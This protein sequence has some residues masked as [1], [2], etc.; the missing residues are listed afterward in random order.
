MTLGLRGSNALLLNRVDKVVANSQAVAAIV[1]TNLSPTLPVEVVSNFVDPETEEAGK[2]PRPSYL[3]ANDGY[4][5]FVGALGRHKGIYELLGAYE[6]LGEGAPPLVLLGTPQ[7]D[8]P[9]Y[10]PHGVIVRK[11][12]P[13]VEVMVAWKHCGFGV[14]PSL[15]PEAFGQ[16]A[17][18]AGAMGK[19][20]VASRTGGLAQLV[21]DERTGLLVS[22]GDVGAL[23]G[24]MRRLLAD[25][26]LASTLGAAGRERAELFALGPFVT[27]LEAITASMVDEHR[28]RYQRSPVVRGA[29]DGSGC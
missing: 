3:P 15:W 9:T 11:N 28:A 2:T 19:A 1:R 4:I 21:Q 22:P 5:L 12:V 16:V 17:V 6:L 18:E 23:A 10:W 24:A 20:V 14:V 13:H 29:R 8:A 26:G 7:L 25:P 27:R